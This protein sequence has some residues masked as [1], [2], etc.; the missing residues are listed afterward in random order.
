M[1][2]SYLSQNTDYSRGANRDLSESLK[3]QLL[4][5]AAEID[6]K[7]SKLKDLGRKGDATLLKPEDR[8]NPNNDDGHG[9]EPILKIVTEADSQ[10]MTTDILAA[11]HELVD[12]VSH[13][14]ATRAIRETHRNQVNE[15]AVSDAKIVELEVAVESREKEETGSRAAIQKDPRRAQADRQ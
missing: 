3:Q 2:Y 14:E 6:D 4:K 9:I 13:L 11:E 7:R 10:K 1:V 5:I 8:L 12:A 15:G